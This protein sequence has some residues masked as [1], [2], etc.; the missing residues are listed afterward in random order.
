MS[1]VET[2]EE[3]NN[4]DENNRITVVNSNIDTYYTDGSKQI[5]YHNPINIE[6]VAEKKIRCKPMYTS[7]ET[8]LE[9]RIIVTQEEEI[10]KPCNQNS[11]C[12]KE[13][14]SRAKKVSTTPNES[15]K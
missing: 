12:C 15:V 7:P 14:R 8:D 4:E 5:R 2:E 1:E 9:E 13:G 3:V 10:G 11:N 6:F